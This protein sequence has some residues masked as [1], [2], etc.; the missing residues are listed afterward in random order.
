MTRKQF[1]AVR[2]FVLG[3]RIRE[4]VPTESGDALDSIVLDNGCVL[5]FRANTDEEVVFD[6]GIP[7]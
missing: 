5:T 7:R 2:D 1:D 6:L 4:L 3:V